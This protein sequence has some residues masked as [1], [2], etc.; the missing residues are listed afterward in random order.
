MPFLED[1]NIFFIGPRASGK[2]SLGRMVAKE[3]GAVFVDMDALLV[4]RA[5][6]SIALFVEKYGWGAFRGLERDLLVE[7]CVN[8]GQVVATG[9]GVVLLPE[10]RD[11]LQKSGGV[12]YLKAGAPVLFSRLMADPLSDQ[13]PA[14]TDKSLEAEISEVLRERGPLYER[15]AHVVLD[16]EAGLED[17]ADAVIKALA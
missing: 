7:I 5:G 11:L 8:S 9:G 15:C 1:A 16:A 14:L 3:L 13:R 2:T 6:E 4:E 12:F 17:M 10:N